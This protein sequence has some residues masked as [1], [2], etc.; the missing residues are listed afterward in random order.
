M[1]TLQEIVTDQDCQLTRFQALK[2]KVLPEKDQ[3]EAENQVNQVGKISVII[4]QV[5]V[6][7]PRLE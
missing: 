5:E 6:L 7:G 2:V 1:L 4:V 3:V